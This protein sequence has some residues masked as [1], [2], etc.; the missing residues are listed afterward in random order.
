MI[1]CLKRGVGIFKN[2]H[3]PFNLS[4]SRHF[5]TT[6]TKTFTTSSKK[7]QNFFSFES[8]QERFK[9]VKDNTNCI[10]KEN[11]LSKQILNHLKENIE[12]KSLKTNRKQSQS[13]IQS[14]FLTTTTNLLNFSQSRNS[15]RNNTLFSSLLS[16]QFFSTTK[17][18]TNLPEYPM[19]LFAS[20]DYEKVCLIVVV[21]IRKQRNTKN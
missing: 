16:S 18:K 20:R 6:F 21:K 8:N 7:N 1:I 9:F 17:T 3:L 15:L 2:K 5:S 19:D 10:W 14:K 12:N 11:S 13:Y 4:I